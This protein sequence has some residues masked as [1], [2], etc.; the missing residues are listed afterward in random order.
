MSSST[1]DV[2][3][4]REILHCFN[5][6]GALDPLDRLVSRLTDAELLPFVRGLNKYVLNNEKKLYELE[7]T[8]RSMDEKGLLAPVLL[9]FGKMIEDD[10]W[11]SS[12]FSL[13]QSGFEGQ[14]QQEVLKALEL[15]S[16]K[17]QSKT[18]SWSL[19]LS[20]SLLQEPFIADLKR[21][22][23]RKLPESPRTLE[24]DA[25]ISALHQYI[26]RDHVY[27][28]DQHVVPLKK[29]WLETV[30][31]PG[32]GDVLS[33]LEQLLGTDE[34]AIRKNAGLISK[35][36]QASLAAPQ[37]DSQAFLLED[38][39][40]AMRDLRRPVE[41][42]EGTR[43][44][45]NAALHVLRELAQLEV[46]E[47][48]PDLAAQFVLRT[49]PLELMTLRPF[50]Q[51]PAEI[52]TYYPA[53]V[54]FA[55]SGAME[56]LARVVKALAT[57]ERPWRGCQGEAPASSEVY[58]PLLTLFLNGLGDLSGSQASGSP[59]SGL[60]SVLAEL[61]ERDVWPELLLI[62]MAP[63]KD[64]L[65]QIQDGVR[66]LFSPQPK[67]SGKSLFDLF[68]TLSAQ[69]RFEDVLQF[70]QGVRKLVQSEDPIVGN[71]LQDLRRAFYVN[72]AHPILDLVHD[73]FSVA[74]EDRDF[75]GALF[76]LVKDPDFSETIRMFS[77]MSQDGRLQ[78]LLGALVNLFHRF[79]ENGQKWVE[80]H[81]TS[82]PAL[83]P[84]RYHL[85]RQDLS[86]FPLH[87]ITE[88]SSWY[89]PSCGELN[90]SF[91]LAEV[92][93][94]QFDQ[95]IR[96]YI[97]CQNGASGQTNVG[98]ALD[99]LLN[100]QTDTQESFLK[101]QVQRAKNLFSS[102]SLHSD[103]LTPAEIHRLTEGWLQ[104]FD[105]GRFFQLLEGIPFWVAPQA[106]SSPMDS[107]ASS[108]PSQSALTH[109]SHSVKG[110]VL[111]P[112][113]EVLHQVTAQA[114]S[115]LAPLEKHL[116][117]VLRHDDFPRLL[118]DGLQMISKKALPVASPSPRV[119]PKALAQFDRQQIAL[120]V[121]YKECATL[122]VDPHVR[123]QQIE[124][125]VEQILD[126]AQDNL[127]NWELVQKP[128]DSLL[129]PRQSWN[130]EEAKQAV[131]PILRKIADRDH[132]SVKERWI[133][134]SFVNFNRYFA[135]PEDAQELTAQEKRQFH[136]APDDLLNWLYERSVDYRLITYYYK[137]DEF[138]RVRLVNSLDLLELTLT[139]VDFMAPFPVSKNMGLDFLSELADA[140]GDEPEERWPEEIRAQ[141]PSAQHRPKTVIQAIEDIVNRPGITGLDN[142]E[143]LT[144]RY[145]GLP[146][147]PHCYRNVPGTQP[148]P[149][150]KASLGWMNPLIIS[151]EQRSE[152]QRHLY[153]LWQSQSVLV[154]NA[155]RHQLN[156]L[157]D[158]FFE[159]KYSTPKSL[160]TP[161]A[162][163][164]NNL[165]V[166]LRSV[167]MGVLRQIGRQLQHFDP[168]DPVLRDFFRSFVHAGSSPEFASLAFTLIQSGAD[169]QFFLDLLKVVFDLLE[170]STPDQR[171]RLNQ[172]A[173]YGVA[174]INRVDPWTPQHPLSKTVDLVDLLLLRSTE[175]VEILGRDFSSQDPSIHHWLPQ[176]VKN[177]EFLLELLKSETLASLP[178][179][180]HETLT[181]EQQ[182]RW[183]T[184]MMDFLAPRGTAPG[185]LLNFEPSLVG[186]LAHLWKAIDSH[187]RSRQS[188]REFF[189]RYD[190]LTELQEY[191]SLD[192]A[193]SW[194]PILKFFQNQAHDGSPS[195]HEDQRLARKLRGHLAQLLDE[196]VLDQILVLEKNNP[197]QFY[198][199][200]QTFSQ[201]ASADQSQGLKKFFSMVRRSLS[202]KSY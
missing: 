193:K 143:K 111:K 31:L 134:D 44:I 164:G 158:L 45:P 10:R 146:E 41:C 90:F 135:T 1:L 106:S 174:N 150:A 5:S 190:Q 24:F 9:S 184:Q 180:I 152:F 151:H 127:T 33:V 74:T 6:S 92:S 113:L 130:Y 99:F 120:W 46:Q 160:R 12:I 175:A 159:I 60:F 82:L 188:L 43:S 35:I 199:T 61:T 101:F 157:R 53:L 105:D 132:Q 147:F 19:D 4:S 112:L 17:L 161:T 39:S 94:P 96:H 81:E 71:F 102:S 50:C 20:H 156:I 154:E 196:G 83:K 125:R 93:D 25:L 13:L 153:N 183:K 97:H 64:D 168:Q 181:S 171:A 15:L 166:V 16:E 2:A 54:R 73:A 87:P 76:R 85:T 155:Q 116:A 37:A 128:G 22:W 23:S 165:S 109:E 148:D 194:D 201:M 21:N 145:I 29:D 51:F 26:Q 114:H 197:E 103:R 176:G 170:Q 48:S 30:L 34:A 163:D 66:F 195:S 202:E 107:T 67:L 187:E 178:R 198:Q 115:H 144:Y 58:R 59:S 172:M 185:Q 133:L 42:M 55:Q 140:W 110:Q 38:L 63:E 8:Y 189:N 89:H 108:A 49:L 139:N 173:F 162:E 65:L 137:E 75:Y 3:Q 36:F 123:Q 68:M 186:N 84:L 100:S 117:R 77:A 136:Y 62:A 79:A 119:R 28:C 124:R 56:P 18:V 91:S 72:D 131:L 98:A 86:P 7:R 88:D 78:E 57:V 121:D 122:S 47:S 40:A 179:V 14:K 95:Q 141:Y 32:Q 167:R 182:Q 192:L 70:A 138:P 104:S 52:Q 169:H 200:L 80:I 118:E 11:V 142:L 27:S 191:R 149:Q 69:A 126:E 129:A 177:H